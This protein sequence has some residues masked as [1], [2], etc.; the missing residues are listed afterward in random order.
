METLAQMQEVLNEVQADA[1]KFFENG[2]KAAGTR[3]RKAMQTIKG[4][5]QDVR[6][7]VSAANN[8]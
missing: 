6:T 8:A 1:T 2:N 4:L 5:A 7:G 3:V